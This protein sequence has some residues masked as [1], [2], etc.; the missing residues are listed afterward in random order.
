MSVY[1]P[2]KGRFWWY[3]FVRKG[4]RYS[5]STG[6]TTRSK[7]ERVEEANRILAAK[8]ELGNDRRPVPTLDQAAAAWWRTKADKKTADEMLTR[9]TVAVKLIGRDKPVNEVT[10]SD[11]HRA[12]QKRRAQ[13]VRGKKTLPSNATINR[14]IIST[15]RP[16]LK[17]A[18]ELLNDGKGAPVAFPEINWGKLRMPEPKPKARG[19]TAA[20][21]DR[22]IA[23]L[24]I[25]LQDFAR[26]QARYG[27]RLEEMFFS[28]DDVDVEGRRL[29]L[30]DRKPGD[31]H[32]LPLTAE[33][34]AML[35]S[36]IGRARAAKIETPWFRELKTGL[37]PVAYWG[38][39]KALGKAMTETGLRATKRARGSHDLRHHAGMEMLRSSNNLRLTQKLLG[40]A[41]INSTLVYA[42]A[43][44][45]DLRAAL[46]KLS[47]PAPSSVVVDTTE[48][49]ANVLKEKKK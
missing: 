16:I 36:R 43:L 34:A 40:H 13:A 35:A 11:V 46:D 42:H 15:I 2:A 48:I 28:I 30:K 45:D 47:Q 20:E 49:D 10:F 5:G 22:V 14:D 8:G 18:R 12:I 33:D 26:F 31:D 23:A 32:S 39:Q 29:L 21:L 25:Y 19:F 27:C 4:V 3:D 38:A 6:A 9:S 7:A 44:E 41:S 24:P 17:L 37:K 1:K